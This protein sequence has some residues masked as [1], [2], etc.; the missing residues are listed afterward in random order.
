MN[1]DPRTPLNSVPGP[2]PSASETPPASR[3]PQSSSAPRPPSSVSALFA[4]SS[5]RASD[6]SSKSSSERKPGE[7]SKKRVSVSAAASS[8][9]STLRANHYHHHRKMKNRGRVSVMKPAVALILLD[10]AKVSDA[11]ASMAAKRQDAVLIVNSTGQ[12]VGILTDKDLAYRL[13]AEGLDPRE[14]P[15]SRIMTANPISVSSQSSA[16]DALNK[17]VA[18]HFRHLPVVEDDDELNDTESVGSLRRSSISSY[19]ESVG[20]SSYAG[21]SNGDADDSAPSNIVGVLDITKCLYDGLERFEKIYELSQKLGED[22]AP[23]LPS[24]QTSAL[25]GDR[26]SRGAVEAGIASPSPLSDLRYARAIRSQLS[27]PTLSSVLKN[28]DIPPP[29]LSLRSTVAEAAKKMRSTRETAVLVF[30]SDPKNMSPTLAAS[31][32]G[33]SL[34]GIFTSKDIVLRVLAAGLDPATTTLIRVMTPHPD[35]VTPNTTILGALQ[36]MHAGRY[37]H[38]PVVDDDGFVEGLVDVL[39]L[40]Y[41]ILSQLTTSPPDSRD[42]PMWNSFWDAILV[43]AETARSTSIPTVPSRLSAPERPPLDGAAQNGYQRPRSASTSSNTRPNGVPSNLSSSPAPVGSASWAAPPSTTRVNAT[44]T[45]SLLDGD[46]ELGLAPSDSASITGS[47]VLSSLGRLGPDRFVY[48]FKDPA[49]GRVHRLTSSS[50]N[51]QAVKDEVIVRLANKRVD[52]A[53]VSDSVS[54]IST[55][56]YSAEVTDQERAQHAFTMSYVDDEGDRV[57][58]FVNRDLEDAIQT[59]RRLGWSRLLVTITRAASAGQ[60][61]SALLA[62]SQ[63]ALKSN[64]PSLAKQSVSVPAASSSSSPPASSS[65]RQTSRDSRDKSKSK[66]SDSGHISA[67]TSGLVVVSGIVLL[68]AVLFGRNLLR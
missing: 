53:P 60:P 48:K 12:L 33:G 66:H 11:A 56:S 64:E 57:S 20:G 43:Q 15:I 32:A 5:K 1:P 21:S 40:T 36:K 31:G 55:M 8:K 13:V 24:D 68:G 49:T 6:A 14:T 16:T 4:S 26:A 42:G 47:Q 35:C 25:S 38:L 30:D 28:V 29:V 46:S 37:L 62:D 59:A 19:P 17:M 58:L 45:S 18:G 50:S 54:V 65:S 39:K 34:A 27:F 52:K 22:A 7:D 63:E 41:T 3:S 9:Q 23:S 67:T 51:L 44:D 61:D 2:S 10:T